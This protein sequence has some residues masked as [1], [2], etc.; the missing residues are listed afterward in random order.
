MNNPSWYNHVMVIVPPW[1]GDNRGWL[2][3]L[4]HITEDSWLRHNTGFWFPTNWLFVGFDNN[5]TCTTLQTFLR[6]TLLYTQFNRNQQW[7]LLG[8]I[9]AVSYTGSSHSIAMYNFS[10]LK[11]ASSRSFYSNFCAHMVND[12]SVTNITF[13]KPLC[14]QIFH[15][16]D[17]SFESKLH[18]A[19]EPNSVQTM[20]LSGVLWLGSVP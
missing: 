1:F 8:L 14:Y 19:L 15:H 13:L 20:V 4:W 10:K 5:K 2:I 3:S 17:W 11:T 7:R 6:R 12:I 18:Y 9:L 16:K